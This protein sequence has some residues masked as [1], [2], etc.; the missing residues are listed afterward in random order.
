LPVLPFIRRITAM[1]T[2]ENENENEDAFSLTL[3]PF[4]HKVTGEIVHLWNTPGN[5]TWNI[6]GA[7]DA[8]HELVVTTPR[9]VIGIS[10]EEFNANYEPVEQK[11]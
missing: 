2:N 5:L 1:P 6:V 11:E 8:A 4:K 9:G 3:I 7:D 10:K